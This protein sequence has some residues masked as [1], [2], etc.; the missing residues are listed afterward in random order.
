MNTGLPHLTISR[1]CGRCWRPSTLSR[2]I[3][4]TFPHS[5]GDFGHDLDAVL[6]RDLRRVFV[7][8][9]P[10]A[11]DILGAALERGDD[12][13]SRHGPEFRSFV[14]SG[15]CEVSVPTMPTR[16]SAAHSGIA[17]ARRAKR[18]ILIV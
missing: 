6:F 15:T 16:R 4:S 5:A 3:A 12:M 2:R 11:L 7:H 14:N 1:I 10:A 18:T 13:R 9:R 17:N 8:A